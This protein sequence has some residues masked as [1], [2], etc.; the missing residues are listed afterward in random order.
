ML[1]LGGLGLLHVA[2]RHRARQLIAVDRR[3]VASRSLFSSA[4]KAREA[5]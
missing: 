1:S 3:I 2:R 4:D 5:T